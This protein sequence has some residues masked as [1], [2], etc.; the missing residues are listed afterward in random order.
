MSTRSRGERIRRS[1]RSGDVMGPAKN[2]RSATSHTDAAWAM[3]S[4]HWLPEPSV[5][6]SA[7][8]AASSGSA[9]WSKVAPSAKR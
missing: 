2:V 6:A 4:R 1:S 7:S 9:R 3:K 8:A 5:S